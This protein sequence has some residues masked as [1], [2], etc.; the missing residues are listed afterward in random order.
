MCSA[1]SAFTLPVPQQHLTQHCKHGF[2]HSWV[3]CRARRLWLGQRMLRGQLIEGKEGGGW[4]SWW[5]WMDSSMMDLINGPLW[6][7]RAS[8]EKE[9]LSGVISHSER[10]TSRALL[11]L[12]MKRSPASTG[13]VRSLPTSQAENRQGCLSQ[14]TNLLVTGCDYS[15]VYVCAVCWLQLL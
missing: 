7:R 2:L 8:P 14:K 4:S 15:S 1:L 11:S 3:L 12:E 5:S 6:L 13:T 10:L 9:A